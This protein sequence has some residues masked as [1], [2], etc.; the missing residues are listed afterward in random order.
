MFCLIA[1]IFTIWGIV[2]SNRVYENL[3]FFVLYVL[4][5]LYLMSEYVK[6]YFEEAKIFTYGPYTLYT[7]KVHLVNV[8]RYIDIYFFSTHPPKSG[9]PCAMPEGYEVGINPRTKM[10]YLQ[11]IGKLKPFKYG[12]Y[13]LYT[14]RIRLKNVGRE[15]DIYFFSSHKPK[16]GK[17]CV[18]PEGYEVGINPR[19][20]MP[21][22]QK[23]CKKRPVKKETVGTIEFIK[24][25]DSD[26][27]SGTKK[28]SN[29]IYVVNK[30]QPGQ[31]KGDWAVRTHGKIYSH[32][33]TQ[34]NAI[35]AARK[36][37][38]QKQATVLVQ[39]VDGKFR[40]GFKPKK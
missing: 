20:K 37:A 7:R 24:V 22:L 15:L 33:R 16:S 32:H 4:I 10:P 1:S 38:K 26:S 21:Y 30:P 36:I 14:K 12:D 40:E 25:E 19:T 3:L 18:M 17:P 5:I 39:G 8:D 9:T 29:V 23:K 34:E 13:T 35:K 27:I 28:P 6:K 11:K 2:I 31:V